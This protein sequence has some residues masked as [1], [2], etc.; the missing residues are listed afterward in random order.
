MVQCPVSCATCDMTS[1]KSTRRIVASIIAVLAFGGLMNALAIFHGWY[2]ETQESA[3]CVF[4]GGCGEVLASPYATFLSI[5]LSIWGIAFY[6][7]M[8]ILG[9]VFLARER[10]YILRLLTLGVFCGLL[11]SLYLFIVQAA[12]I[13]TFCSS[14]LFSFADTI[15]MAGAVGAFFK[16]ILK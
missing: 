1:I 13:G 7:G 15:L 14:C 5:P 8:V 11:F 16:N 6:L 10:V 9:L 3:S 12:I 2:G 4:G